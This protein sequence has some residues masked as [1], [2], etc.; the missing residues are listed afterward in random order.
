MRSRGVVLVAR[1]VLVVAATFQQAESF[2]T[3]TKGLGHATEELFEDVYA[4]L[5]DH[6]QSQ[7]AELCGERQARASP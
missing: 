6:L 1:R 3:W 7:R 4:T 5:P 2:G